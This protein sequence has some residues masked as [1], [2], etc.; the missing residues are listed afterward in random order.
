V[1][2]LSRDL[3]IRHHRIGNQWL[4]R[5]FSTDRETLGPYNYYFHLG[6]VMPGGRDAP[7]GD[8]CQE[9][10]LKPQQ[11]ACAMSYELFNMPWDIMGVF[12][13]ITDVSLSGLQLMHG[14]TID[15]GYSGYL[16]MGVVNL[17]SKPI[18]LRR[19][20]RIG[21]VVFINVLDTAIEDST[22]W[23]QHVL[24]REE[25]SKRLPQPGPI[26]EEDPRE[27]GL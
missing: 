6:S 15:P 7:I 22:V 17:G 16:H 2:V 18:T 21:K 12:G 1:F 19:A 10:E 13:V 9:W 25:L 3:L 8:A 14:P 11:F 4:I 24:D 5:P 20:M 23:P 27:Y 26:I